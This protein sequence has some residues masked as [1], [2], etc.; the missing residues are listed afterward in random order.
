MARGTAASD[1]VQR[2][3]CPGRRRQLRY[4]CGYQSPHS[5]GTARSADTYARC[6]KGLALRC[7]A[8]LF[9]Q[10]VCNHKPLDLLSVQLERSKY[11]CTAQ[12]QA[13]HQVS[14]RSVYSHASYFLC[15]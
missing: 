11:I 14:R 7:L 2:A 10:D 6:G 4:H 1:T 15:V 9:G 3:R 12:R 8:K 5:G 13:P